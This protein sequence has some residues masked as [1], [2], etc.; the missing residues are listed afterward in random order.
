MHVV[1][2]ITYAP[3]GSVV[4]RDTLAQPFVAIPPGSYVAIIKSAVC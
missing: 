4:R 3:D 2:T 1:E